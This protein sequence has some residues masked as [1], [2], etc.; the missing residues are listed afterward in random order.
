MSVVQGYKKVPAPPSSA[1]D[2]LIALRVPRRL[3]PC[4]S[5]APLS[6]L[7]GSGDPPLLGAVAFQQLASLG[8]RRPHIPSTGTSQG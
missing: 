7:V 2:H 5:V 8:S 1:L 6:C 3:W 4:P